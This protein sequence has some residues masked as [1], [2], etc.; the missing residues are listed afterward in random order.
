MA[1]ANSNNIGILLGNRNGSFETM[2]IYSTGDDS[3]PR[4][5]VVGDFNNDN[6]SDIAV[7]NSGT[8]N[9][10]IFLGYGNGSFANMITYST[11]NGSNPR[12]SRCW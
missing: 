5:I 4:G 8:N 7:T 12:G 2:L 10:A 1:F 6:H 9:I 11:G 3:Y